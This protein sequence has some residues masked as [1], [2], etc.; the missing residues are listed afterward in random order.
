MPSGSDAGLCIRTRFRRLPCPDS[1][2]T[3]LRGTLKSVARN[4]SRRVFAL[5]SAGGALM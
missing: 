2:S 5:P 1:S 4:Y 3:C